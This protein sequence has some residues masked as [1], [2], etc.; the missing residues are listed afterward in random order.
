MVSPFF[1][2]VL[3]DRRLPFVL[4]V[5]KIRGIFLVPL[6]RVAL[7]VEVFLKKYIIFLV[8]VKN[9]PFRGRKNNVD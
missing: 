7:E 6:G 4:N 3:S 8:N 2:N 5:W 1:Y 9:I